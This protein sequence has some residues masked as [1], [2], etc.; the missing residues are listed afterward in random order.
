MKSRI[1]NYLNKF[2]Y[3]RYLAYRKHKYDVINDYK[4]EA[5]R[6]YYPFFK[7][8]IDWKN[9]KNLI[10]K[11]YW[12]QFNSDTSLWTKCADKYL[13]RDFVK[14]K[15][16]SEYLPKL[17]GKWE[18]AKEIDFDSLPNRFVIKTNNAC[19]KNLI[20]TDKTKLN[21]KSTIKKLNRWLSIPYGY[22]AAQLH[23]TSINPCL[24]AEEFLEN[25]IS[26]SSSLIDYKVWC[27]HGKPEIVLV[28]FNRSDNGV[29]LSLYDLNWNKKS[30][31]LLSSDHYR[32]SKK[33]IPKPESLN[34]MIEI[35]KV[36]SRNIPQVRIDFYDI[37]GKPYFGEMTFT[38]GFGRSFTKEYYDYLGSKID[39]CKVE[40]LI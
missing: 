21:I 20:V 2:H 19:G 16:F 23:Y 10:E 9:P 11:I 34:K 28:V 33:E 22:A 14:E 35:A 3:Y 38:S 13:V 27:F 15:G 36:L 29:D 12:L 18:N 30:E 6:Y 31:F 26:F 17:Y 4:K 39:L 37:N 5:N 1:L 25:N 8:K 7:S 40:L 24:I 32:Y